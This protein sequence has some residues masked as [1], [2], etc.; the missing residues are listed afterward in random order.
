MGACLSSPAAAQ[1]AGAH[2]CL[3][4]SNEALA[5]PCSAEAHSRPAAAAAAAPFLN[6][7]SLAGER[8]ASDGASNEGSAQR[9]GSLRLKSMTRASLHMEFLTG[10]GRGRAALPGA[11]PTASARPPP[12]TGTPPT[13]SKPRWLGRNPA[14]RA[15]HTAAHGPCTPSTTPTPHPHP[16]PMR[17][18][19][20]GLQQSLALVNDNPLLGLQEAAELLAGQLSADLAA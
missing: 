5:K 4:C 7:L 19:V 12:A 1:H 14:R 6:P 17:A 8:D 2:R 3:D 16:H 20:H 13:C 18:E 9:I 15:A 10:A 11:R